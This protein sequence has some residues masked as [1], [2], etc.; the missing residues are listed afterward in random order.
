[1]SNP[2]FILYGSATGNSEDIAKDLAARFEKHSVAS[3]HFDGVVCCELD[4]FKKKCVSVW[5][6]EPTSSSYKKYG[7]LIVASTTGNGDAPENA[8]RFVRF[9]KRKGTVDQQPFRHC[10]Y[11]VLGL[12]DTNY[13]QFCATGKLID[14]KLHELGGTR[15]RAVECADEGTGNFEDVI[16]PWTESILT[17]ITNAC[18][19]N[20]NDPAAAVGPVTPT[21]QAAIVEEEKK[22]QDAPAASTVIPVSKPDVADVASVQP[23]AGVQMVKT[24][25]QASNNSSSIYNIDPKMLPTMLSSRSSCELVDPEKQNTLKGSPINDAASS[26]S[27]GF[28]YTAKNA[29][30]SHVIKARY[31]TNTS[32][33]AVTSDADVNTATGLQ[34][35]QTAIDESF[36]LTVE[37]NGKRVIELTL[38]VPDDHT[39]EY[40]PG[41][42]LGLLVENTPDAVEFC[43]DMLKRNHGMDPDQMI[44][45]DENHPVTV[46][47]ALKTELDLCSTV[48][49]KRVLYA[50][51]QVATNP[52]EAGSL[53]LLSSKT[54]EE[55]FQRVVDGQRMSVVDLL[56]AFPSTQGVS[57]EGLLSIVPGIPPRYYSVSSSPIEHQRVSLTVAFSVVDYL[58]PSF[59]VADEE[60]GKRRIRGIATRYLEAISLP[61]L[62]GKADAEVPLVGIFPK[63]T[64]E[65]R[66]PGQVTQ[67]LILIGPGT[68]IAPFMGFLQ[69]RKALMTSNSSQEAAQTVVEG[70]WRG[71]FELEENEMAVSKHDSSGLNVGADFRDSVKHGSVDV[72][73][74]CRYQDHD[75]LYREELQE[76]AKEGIVTKLHTAF[77]RDPGSKHKY[78]QDIMLNDEA[79]A[80][81]LVDLIV[82]QNA[83]V[84]VCGDGNNMA[85]DVQNA[86]VELLGKRKF[87]NEGGLD[88]A[89]SYLDTMKTTQRFLLDIWS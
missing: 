35:A 42:S 65:F 85:K 46:E 78:V 41:D 38:S 59:A 70:A 9:C 15:L 88:K 80:E 69:H 3:V 56:R 39:L 53:Q 6:T 79:C 52:D 44:S 60:V 33:D 81:R 40:A 74:G 64:S 1:M 47:T 66:M 84:Y 63:P 27:S 55:L 71:G 28:H 8:G 21:K 67:P 30:Q 16:E 87:E 49:S 58:T 19:R 22:T 72:F 4:Q 51:S 23:S 25:L 73:F 29:Y 31:L 57:I 89:K 76:L 61:L 34:K 18:R 37:R 2:L 13:D 68:G 20:N 5:E 62:A 26:V 77:S 10:A 54:G 86:I 83:A 82:N 43:L 12:G 11:A 24:L 36:P 75:W 17:E 32:I 7:V 48:K 45:I 14:K 50:L